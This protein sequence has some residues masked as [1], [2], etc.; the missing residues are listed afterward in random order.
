MALKEEAAAAAAQTS[1]SDSLTVENNTGRPFLGGD[2][3]P[4]IRMDYP[5][6]L[7]NVFVIAGFTLFACI[8][9]FVLKNI[10]ME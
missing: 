7:A 1:T 5:G 3:P 9:K 8:V 2:L 6:L 4:R 10:A